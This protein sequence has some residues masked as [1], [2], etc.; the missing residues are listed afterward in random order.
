[1]GELWPVTQLDSTYSHY[2]KASFGYKI[3][4]VGTIS[5]TL[6]GDFI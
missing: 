2:R 5:P 4:P 1:M 3:Y 6:F